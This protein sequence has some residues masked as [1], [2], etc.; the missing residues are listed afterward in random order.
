S[1]KK[2]YKWDGSHVMSYANGSKLFRWR[3][4]DLMHYSNARKVLRIQGVVPVA[5][6]IALVTGQV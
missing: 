4:P 5:L 2:L 1:G 3:G 6:V